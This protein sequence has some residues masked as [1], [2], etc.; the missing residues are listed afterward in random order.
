MVILLSER[1]PW[2]APRAAGGRRGLPVLPAGGAA[3]V[4]GV[5]AG[6]QG[7]RVSDAQ[8]P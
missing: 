2:G 1:A 7:R 4:S 8:Q 3:E 5:R 6:P